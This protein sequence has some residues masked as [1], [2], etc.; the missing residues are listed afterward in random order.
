V[1]F[2]VDYGDGTA[3]QELTVVEQESDEEE[4]EAEAVGTYVYAS[5]GTYTVTVTATPDVGQAATVTV[6][7]VVT[8]DPVAYPRGTD[9]ACPDGVVAPSGFGD[10]AAGSTH[11]APIDCLATRGLVQGTGN[12]TYAPGTTVTRAQMATFLVR[13]LDEAGVE[14]PEDVEDAFDDDDGN[15]HEAAIN[16][17]AAAGLLTGS[18]DGEVVP[19]APLTRAQMA[20]LLVRALEAA[21][22]ELTSELDYFRDDDGSTHEAAINLAAAAGVGTGRQLLEFAPG[23]KLSRAQ[24]ATFLTRALDLLLDTEAPAA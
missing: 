23:E 14:L 10:V 7:V 1:V 13:L 15:T 11:A 19:Q 20:A 16:R 24:L 22:S 8:T 17:L 9:I 12:G 2:T 6:G 3:A 5:E 21:G 4:F 18:A